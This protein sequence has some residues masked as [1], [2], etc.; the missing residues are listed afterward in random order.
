MTG[1]GSERYRAGKPFDSVR[2]R[3][4]PFL[5]TAVVDVI[6]AVFEP[7]LNAEYAAQDIGASGERRAEP[8]AGA[9]AVDADLV[10]R[11]SL[12]EFVPTSQGRPSTTTVEVAVGVGD[13]LAD[14]GGYEPSVGGTIVQTSAEYAPEPIASA[15]RTR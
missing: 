7:S 1:K 10:S 2:S 11:T 15:A 12:A 5:S 8:G 9:G 4:L 6:A 3:G 13:G 14:G